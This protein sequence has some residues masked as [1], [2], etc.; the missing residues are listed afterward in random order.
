MTISES[1]LETLNRLS[2]DLT[3]ARV[4]SLSAPSIA[5][6]ESELCDAT[7]EIENAEPEDCEECATYEERLDAAE[8]ALDALTSGLPRTKDECLEFLSSL[9]A[10]IAPRGVPIHGK[11]VGHTV[12]SLALRDAAEFAAAITM[13]CKDALGGKP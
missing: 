10:A 11:E 1:T 12:K 2:R 13:A 4:G 5:E 3:L 6:L 8:N 9:F 7:A